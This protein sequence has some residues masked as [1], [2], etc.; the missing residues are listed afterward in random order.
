MLEPERAPGAVANFAA[1]ADKGS[2]DG[3][4]FH[5]VVPDFVVQGGDPDGTGWGGPGWT[6]RDEFS[7]RPYRRGTVGMA[8]SGVDTAGSQWFIALSRH[9]H[10]DGHY[11]A[12]GRVVDQDLDLLD[13]IRRGEAIR[14]VRVLRG[15]AAPE[16]EREP[17]QD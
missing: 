4:L 13:G 1:L 10:L 15:G 16:R 6:L 2:Y 9:P 14:S 8:R 3:L 7:A 11:T 17:W 5:R 12:F